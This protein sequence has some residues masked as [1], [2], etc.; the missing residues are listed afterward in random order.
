MRGQAATGGADPLVAIAGL[1]VQFGGV[2]V[3]HGIDLAVRRGE[4]LGLVGESG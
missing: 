1:R 3:L 4:S 2:P